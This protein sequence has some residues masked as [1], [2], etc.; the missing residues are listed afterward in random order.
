MFGV[1]VTIP[2]TTLVTELDASA[3]STSYRYLPA[4]KLAVALAVN[5]KVTTP[6]VP[7]KETVKLVELEDV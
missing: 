7:P 6:V 5:D 2:S 1:T 4:V 3:I